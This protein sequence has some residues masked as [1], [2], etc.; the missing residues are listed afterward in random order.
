MN[1]PLDQTHQAHPALTSLEISI[2]LK[3]KELLLFLLQTFIKDT[4]KNPKNQHQGQASK[5][6]ASMTENCPEKHS[7]TPSHKQLVDSAWIPQ[8]DIAVISVEHDR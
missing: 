8:A 2:N 1:D 5:T 6:W 3:L 4:E 7:T